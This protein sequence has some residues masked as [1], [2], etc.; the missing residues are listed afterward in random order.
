MKFLA[1]T[2]WGGLGT[3][4]ALMVILSVYAKFRPRKDRVDVCASLISEPDMPILSEKRW[5]QLV[6]MLDLHDCAPPENAAERVA[7][8]HENLGIEKDW[9]QGRDSAMYPLLSFH[10]AVE[11]GIDFIH[12][13]KQHHTRIILYVVK[14]CGVPLVEDIMEAGTVLC[15]ATS[16]SIAGCSAQH[17]YPVN[18]Y[19]EWGY[20]P[21][22]VQCSQIV[23]AAMQA[24]IE[25][26][27]VEVEQ[28][29]M[30]ALLEGKSIPTALVQN[31]TSGWDPHSVASAG[32]DLA[33]VQKGM[34]PAQELKQHLVE[35]GWN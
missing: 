6:A 29:D 16:A 17:F 14:P 1:Y 25:V 5:D 10:N 34:L 32:E 11:K 33:A 4:G 28:G 7:W 23:Y 12:T 9:L 30:Y 18:V 27:G 8:A 3:C 24:A 15:F 13:L 2:I 31:A 35:L 19:W 26:R 22:R 21:E 20:P